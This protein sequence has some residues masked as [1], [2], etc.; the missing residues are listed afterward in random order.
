MCEEVSREKSGGDKEMLEERK[1]I[2]RS[3]QNYER[4]CWNMGRKVGG[5]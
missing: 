2:I 5:G 3:C 4:E 1:D